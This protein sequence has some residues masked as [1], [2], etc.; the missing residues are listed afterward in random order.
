MIISAA[1]PI[2]NLAFTLLFYVYLFFTLYSFLG[3]SYHGICLNVGLGS[4]KHGSISS[5]DGYAI[6][7]KNI[8]VGLQL[9][10]RLGQCLLT[11]F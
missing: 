4:F 9:P 3:L 1:G 6:F 11:I 2:V 8:I 7:K 10:Y 5:L